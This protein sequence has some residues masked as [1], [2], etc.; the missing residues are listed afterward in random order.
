MIALPAAISAAPSEGGIFN[1]PA[2]DHRACHHLAVGY[3]R[4]GKLRKLNIVMVIIK[5]VVLGVLHH[6]GRYGDQH[7]QLHAVRAGRV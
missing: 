4:A 3:W 2:V 5:L 7:R 6:R 1:L